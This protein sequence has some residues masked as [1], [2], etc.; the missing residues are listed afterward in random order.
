MIIIL[1]ICALIVL[2]LF[3]FVACQLH[4]DGIE[5]EI[6]KALLNL[7]TVVI[8]TQAGAI[9]YSRYEQKKRK[10]ELS[11][12]ARMRILDSLTLVFGEIKRLRRKIRSRLLF[13]DNGAAVTRDAISLEVYDSSLNEINA[14]QITLEAVAKDVENMENLFSKPRKVF[15]AVS[16]MEA[17]LNTMVD[18]W[19]HNSVKFD[20][21]TSKVD[22]AEFPKLADFL[23]EYK[24]SQFRKEFV[25]KYYSAADY[26]RA[27]LMDG[28]ST[29]WKL[30]N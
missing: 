6:A 9:V 30:K 14:M 7:L 4:P 26:M 2:G 19:E 27:D 18:E 22:I 10:D 21:H 28:R 16:Q 29:A 3:A 5:L 8:V 15:D 24:S 12:S 13:L 17:Y 11:D 1:S 20:D 25:H 23:G